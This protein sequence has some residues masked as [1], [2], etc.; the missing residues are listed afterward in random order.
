MGTPER[1]AAYALWLEVERRRLDMKLN[2]VEL[3]E[4]S[5]VSRG[6][7]DRLKSGKQPPEQ[8]TVHALARVLHIDQ[9]HAE[10]LAG[11]RPPAPGNGQGEIDV[12]A[13]IQASPVYTERQRQ[14]LLSLVDMFEEANGQTGP[15]SQAAATGSE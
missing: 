4:L 14:M 13:A 1:G 9:V 3:A 6:T 10:V 2:K 11:L 5:G 12:R 15:G 8:K 7:I